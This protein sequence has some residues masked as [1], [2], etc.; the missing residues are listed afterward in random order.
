MNVDVHPVV[1]FLIIM[2][3]QN[4]E[5]TTSDLESLIAASKPVKMM[6]LQCGTPQSP[7]EN[8][9]AAWK[10][11]GDRMGFDHMT[12]RPTG[13]GDRFFSA[14]SSNT[15]MDKGEQTADKVKSTKD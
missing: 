9:N 15:E 5:M 11:L 13:K 4:Y 3:R 2:N 8:A 10:R 12:V 14:I 6:M 7:Q 1:Q